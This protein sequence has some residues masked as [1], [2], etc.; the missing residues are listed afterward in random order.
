MT[1]GQFSRIHALVAE[2]ADLSGTFKGS[3]EQF[4]VDSSPFLKKSEELAALVQSPEEHA[5]S[6]ILRTM[7]TAVIRTLLSLN[8][9]QT[10]PSTGSISLQDLALAT[11]TQ[12]SL[13]ERLLR[14]VTRTDFIIRENG[15]YRHTHTSLAYNG[16]LGALFAPCYDEGI[17]ALIRLPE[18]LAVKDK[19]EAKSAMHS[20]FTWNEG[21]DGKATFEILS[22]MPER[23]EGVHTL[24]MNVQHLRP[25][26]GVFDYAKIA[27][28]DS[29]RIVFVDVGGGSGHVIKE[30]LQAFPQIRP[31]QCVL[32]DRAETLELARTTGLLP[33]GVQLLE[34]DYL[35]RQPISN[36]KA[37]HLRAVAYN[38]GDIE[39][40]QLLKQIVPVMGPD[41]KVLI[42]ENILFA[43]NGTAF[44]TVSD[45]IMLCIGGKE[46]TERNFCEVL[47]EAGLVIDGV[48]RASGLE[49]GIVEASLKI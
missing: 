37:Y 49:Y 40:V 2:I 7:E 34:H 5:T 30:I 27:C 39:L 26:A 13:L 29:E 42:A 35:A 31:E 11:K 32:E 10:I 21:H 43:D 9:I 4:M 15:G 46:R 41:S 25:Y 8:V 19:E 12:A 18:Y 47:D 20:P 45:M 17:R 33:S 6:L 23:M 24:A 22:T 28:E 36:A 14:V 16:L 1:P 38:L 3:S 48:H 44:S